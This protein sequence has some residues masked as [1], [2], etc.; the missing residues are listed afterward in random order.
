VESMFKHVADAQTPTAC[1]LLDRAAREMRVWG[2]LKNVAL[3]RCRCAAS[4]C[5]PGRPYVVAQ[6]KMAAVG[7]C[8]P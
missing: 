1:L 4:L 7:R 6:H 3:V 8:E 2:D 5:R